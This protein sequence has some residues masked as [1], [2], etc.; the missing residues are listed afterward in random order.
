MPTVQAKNKSDSKAA[1]ENSENQE[2]YDDEE[3]EPGADGNEKEEEDNE[4]DEVE[5]E[6]NEQRNRFPEEE[7]SYLQKKLDEMDLQA[8][9]VQTESGLEESVAE[10]QGGTVSHLCLIG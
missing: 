8:I 3:E 5:K 6:E 10:Y 7:I 4:K 2:V 1:N 9:P